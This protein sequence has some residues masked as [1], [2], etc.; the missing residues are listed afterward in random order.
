MHRLLKLAL[1]SL[2]VLTV[3]G[4]IVVRKFIV[5]AD[6]PHL[7]ILASKAHR[8]D[9]PFT[10]WVLSFYT[11][12]KIQ[13]LV[14]FWKGEKHG[15]EIRWHSNGQRWLERPFQYGKMHGTHRGWYP[16]GK[17]LF[18]R[19]YVDDVDHGEYWA[20]HPNG[21]VSNFVRFDRGV[22]KAVKSWASF[23]AVHYNYVTGDNERIGVQGGQYCRTKNLRGI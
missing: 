23:G 9:E 11:G 20:W 21:Q 14:P 16:D 5:L 6:D 18:S 7:E 15:L 10:G 19:D 12:F 4:S 1:C 2:V 13:S 22:E 8:Y 17:V 3:G